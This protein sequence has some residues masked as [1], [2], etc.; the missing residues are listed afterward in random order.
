MYLFLCS[1]PSLSLQ[2]QLPIARR[3][4]AC[5][6]CQTSTHS[7]PV[8]ATEPPSPPPLSQQSEARSP[9]HAT[10][11]RRDVEARPT[12]QPLQPGVVALEA[13]DAFCFSAHGLHTL[14]KKITTFVFLQTWRGPTSLVWSV[15]RRAPSP[16]ISDQN[17][18]DGETS[19]YYD[20][21]HHGKTNIPSPQD[22]REAYLEDPLAVAPAEEE[23]LCLDMERRFVISTQLR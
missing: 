17:S 20:D 21:Y 9:V 22:R 7:S 14:K 4:T 15:L 6:S 19:V 10:S 8:D 1:Q 13:P 16:K 2:F 11:H 3:C 23:S 5:S 12:P 18:N